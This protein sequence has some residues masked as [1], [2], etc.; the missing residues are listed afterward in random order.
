[1]ALPS[2]KALSNAITRSKGDEHAP[3]ITSALE[4]LNAPFD[5]K[6]PDGFREEVALTLLAESGYSDELMEHIR[7]TMRAEARNVEESKIS[8]PRRRTAP[9]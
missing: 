2:L 5:G 7:K 4:R 6:V 1:M 8:R 9:R 3:H